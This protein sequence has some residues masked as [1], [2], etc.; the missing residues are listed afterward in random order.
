MRGRTR[1]W[2]LTPL[3]A[4]LLLA[5]LPG[6]AAAAAPPA[7]R[8]AQ[9]VRLTGPAPVVFQQL[10]RL[11]GVRLEV[12][13]TLPARALRL[14]LG[15][16]DFAS[17]L[18]AATLLAGA[19]AV[20][21]PDGSVFVAEDTPANRS[22]FQPQV[23]RTFV[24]PG[25]TPE[26]LTETVRL[27]RELLDMRRLLPDPAT[28]T[29][30]VR[31]TPQRLAVAEALLDQ[32][33][34]EPGEVLLDVSVLEIDRSRALELGLVPPD[35]II[36]ENLG[37]GALSSFIVTL[38]GTELRLQQLASVTR[39]LRHLTLRAREG[40]EATLFAGDLFP[41]IFATFSSSFISP[42]E[43]ELRDKGE[44]RPP[45]PA[46]RFEELGVRVR[47]RPRLHSPEEV[48]LAL[49]IDQKALAGTQLND[50][51]VISNRSLEHQV[52]LRA[53]ETLLLGGFRTESRQ[54]TTSG[55]FLLRETTGET[56]ELLVLVTP[57][58]MR[59]PVPDRLALRPLYVGT[60][61]EFAPA[62][63]AGPAVQPPRPPEP[64]AVRPPEPPPPPEEE[65]DKDEDR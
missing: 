63:A 65:K 42:L 28:N 24:L 7:A 14:Q 17:A 5:A 50:I 56:T 57:R 33:L 45:V 46:M 6:A 25:R 1:L 26:E 34:A 35:T 31:D 12:E 29:F 16:A 21:R 49:K 40:E 27:L 30:T 53:G 2:A 15:E 19:F 52:R 61:N 4:G 37:G 48:S 36:A 11:Y 22:R 20:E 13:P 23:M 32:V 9:D 3:L 64:P 51:P 58:I 47:A 39:S 10:G 44:F 43:Q 38:P 62:G 59:L 18:R 54:A 55:G 41:V 8:A 60:E